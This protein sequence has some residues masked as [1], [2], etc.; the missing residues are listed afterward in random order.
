[1]TTLPQQIHQAI[2]TSIAAGPDFTPLHNPVFAGNEEAFLVDCVRSNFVSSV[3]AYVERF[4]GMLAEYTGVRRAVLTVNG[5]AALHIALMLAGVGRGDEVLLPA[6]TFVATA[7]AV[8]YLGAT[9]HFIE[10]EPRSLGVDAVALAD[11]LAEVAE[12]RGDG[13]YNRRSGARIAALA[14]MHT[15]GHP[16]D[17]DPLMALAH[18]WRLPL[19]E[20]AAESLGS[21]Y[22]G[23]H[24]GGFGQLGVLSFNGNKIITTGGGGAILTNDDALADRAK[25]L[26]TTAKAPHRWEYFHD[27]VGYN[28][29]MPAL[30]AALGCAQ[31]EQLG[32]FLACKRRLAARYQAA[33]ADLAGVSFFTQPDYAQSN[34]WLN[35]L[36]LNEETASQ[37]D[38]VLDY[39]N[40]HGIMTRPVWRLLHQLPIYAP[41]PTM[42]LPQ[43]EDLARRI[44]NIPSS[45]WLAEK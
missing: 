31:M 13:C 37:R 40:S 1:M 10:V 2:R 33:F 42:P 23:R 25:H 29:R 36:I 26:T 20:D 28:Y 19:V 15:F 41:C 30:N 45:A 18:R 44:I 6:L 14:P 32:H 35:T 5:T 39:T 17:L 21:F 22:R 4:E 9:P 8:A 24:T 12:V 43:S 7:N 16:V 11:Y 3:G 34:Y 27:A 38:A